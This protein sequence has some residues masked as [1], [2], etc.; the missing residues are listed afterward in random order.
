MARVTSIEAGVKPMTYVRPESIFLHATKFN[1][2]YKVLV[3][4]G[5][6]LGTSET[7]ARACGLAGVT[8]ELMLKCLISLEANSPPDGH[9]LLPLFDMLSAGT[10]GRLQVKWAEHVQ[11][12]RD[13]VDMVKREGGVAVEPDLRLALEVG[14]KAFSVVRYWYEGRHREITFYLG[15]L[16]DLL[17]EVALELRPDWAGRPEMVWHAPTQGG[18]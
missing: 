5:A 17:A 13:E 15:A 6:A 14:G 12:N 8:S 1:K 18:A 9:D 10:Q 7:V 3:D 11:A 2:A 4:T 16:P